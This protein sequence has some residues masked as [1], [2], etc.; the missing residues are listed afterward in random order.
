MESYQQQI[1]EL[2]QK[3]E[4]LEQENLC[5]KQLLDEA[6]ISYNEKNIA[7]A[8]TDDNIMRVCDAQI[9]AEVLELM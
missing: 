8:Q 7:G 5:L 3:I 4:Q 9:A 6:G 2:K 1:A